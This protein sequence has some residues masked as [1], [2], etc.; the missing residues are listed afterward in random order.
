MA[1]RGERRGAGNGS[2]EGNPRERDYLEDLNIN[3]RIIL[4]WVFKKWGEA[5]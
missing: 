5:V 4:K 3:G 1:F 2:S